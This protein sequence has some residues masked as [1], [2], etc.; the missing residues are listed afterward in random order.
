MQAE[1]S[2]RV[3][4]GGMV[5]RPGPS[6]TPYRRPRGRKAHVD[7][8]RSSKG[9]CGPTVLTGCI[10]AAADSYGDG[11]ANWEERS[12]GWSPSSYST[13]R[14]LCIPRLER[15]PCHQGRVTRTFLIGAIASLCSESSIVSILPSLPR[16]VGSHG[17]SSF[18]SRPVNFSRTL[19][20]S[21]AIVY[22]PMAFELLACALCGG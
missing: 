9:R 15:C 5:R 13:L 4:C 2:G 1:R 20:V 6:H 3:R 18:L 11:I 12:D 22:A 10:F 16:H 21:C 7:H 14:A 8:H 19:R 17:P